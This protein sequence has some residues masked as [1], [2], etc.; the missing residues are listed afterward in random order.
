MGGGHRCSLHCSCLTLTAVT[1]AQCANSTHRTNCPNE[2]WPGCGRQRSQACVGDTSNLVATTQ[3][4]GLQQQ[5][6]YCEPPGLLDIQGF[7]CAPPPPSPAL[8][9]GRRARR[10]PTTWTSTGRCAHRRTVTAPAMHRPAPGH[11]STSAATTTTTTRWPA[12][13]R[14]GGPA[15]RAGPRPQ[16]S[17]WPSRP[18]SGTWGSPTRTGSR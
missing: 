10:G 18:S 1:Q 7:T 16:L 6:K 17:L 8:P 14:G 5:H 2:F 3:R 11:R 9:H 13:P 12:D 4:H 15:Q